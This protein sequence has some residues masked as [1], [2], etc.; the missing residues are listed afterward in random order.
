MQKAAIPSKTAT[1]GSF[2]KPW[3]LVLQ[4]HQ[5]IQAARGLCWAAGE[6]QQPKQITSRDSV[7]QATKHF[8]SRRL[9]GAPTSMGCCFYRF[10]DEETK[11][12]KRQ[13][14]E[15]DLPSLEPLVLSCESCL[16]QNI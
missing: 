13:I 6:A 3:T 2:S 15:V 16:I 1:S 11:T 14:P 8:L 5:V 10:R 9:A 4:A 7:L 12:S